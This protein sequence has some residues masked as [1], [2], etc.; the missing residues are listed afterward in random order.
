MRLSLFAC[1]AALCGI[2]LSVQGADAAVLY[3]IDDGSNSLVTIDRTTGAVTVV[4]ATG[5]ATGDFGDLTYDSANNSLYWVPG[6]GNNNLYTISQTTGVATLVGAHNINDMFG[7]AYDS[8]NNTLYGSDTAGNFYSLSTTT[9]A[10]TLI[11][12]N[13]IYPGGLAYVS[14]TNTLYESASGGGTFYSINP[15]N[16]AMTTIT[17]AG[18]RLNDNGITWDPLLGQFWSVDWNSNINLINSGFTGSTLVSTYS[19][20]L[21]GVA[22][23]GTAPEPASL[24][25]LGGALLALGT[26]RRRRRR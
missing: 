20:P 11:G 22:F 16:G 3:A 7:L 19:S 24:T 17:T 8:A 4:G 5:V 23:V 18:P 6:R 12:N 21:D 1:A 13:T 2:V 9:G 14:A 10:A 15:A 26:S 25:L